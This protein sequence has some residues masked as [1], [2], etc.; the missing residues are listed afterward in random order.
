[1]SRSVNCLLQTLL[2]KGALLCRTTDSNAYMSIDLRNSNFWT[3]LHFQF[4]LSTSLQDG[5]AKLKS[6]SRPPPPPPLPCPSLSP[7][8]DRRLHAQSHVRRLRIFRSPFPATS[9]PCQHSF[10]H[11][12]TRNPCCSRLPG[13]FRKPLSC[14]RLTP[15]Q[16]SG[17]G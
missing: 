8:H 16:L 11:Q 10:N 15:I 14:P 1:M 4:G 3:F 7:R 12:D 9:A 13:C 5:V 2:P 17:R 6:Q